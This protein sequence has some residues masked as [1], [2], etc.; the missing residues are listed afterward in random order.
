MELWSHILRIFRMYTATAK[1]FSAHLTML[2]RAFSVDIC[3][4]V[5]PSVRCVYYDNTKLFSVSMST[6]YDRRITLV[7]S[8]PNFVV[9]SLG[10][11]RKRVC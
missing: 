1:V 9:L 8:E 11:R 4:S 6:S 3:L 10:V 7:S 5:R 2:G